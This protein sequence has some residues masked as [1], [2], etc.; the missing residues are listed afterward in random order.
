MFQEPS[1]LQEATVRPSG[2]G[3]YPNQPE[4]AQEDDQSLKTPLVSRY[5]GHGPIEIKTYCNKLLL[6]YQRS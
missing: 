3:Q 6:P 1:G 5:K 2:P 4:V